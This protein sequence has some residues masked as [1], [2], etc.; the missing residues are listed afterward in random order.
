[1][2]AVLVILTVIDEDVLAVQHVLGLMTG[3]GII[4][5]VCRACIP[6]EV[7]HWDRIYC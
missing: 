4:I 7:C 1:M 6:D 3:L 5:T 2:L